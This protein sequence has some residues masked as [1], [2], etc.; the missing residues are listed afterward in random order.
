[1]AEPTAPGTG[2]A[3][4]A[5]APDGVPP[6][7]S[8]SSSS[9]SAYAARAAEEAARMRAERPPQTEAP[10]PDQ[11]PPQPEASKKPDDTVT[12]IIDAG[13]D[14][15]VVSRD[16]IR[17]E[18]EGVVR[19]KIGQPLQE[20]GAAVGAVWAA[21]SLLVVGLLFIAVAALVWL[22]QLIGVPLAFL[23][24]GLVYLIG[25][26]VFL[27]LKIRQMRANAEALAKSQELRGV[28]P[29]PDTTARKA[30]R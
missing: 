7:P 15:L 4:G 9:S 14:L 24:V 16:W 21:A 13:A 30:T 3:P 18:T 29:P 6:G 19:E 23:V 11:R 28:Q 22:C 26:A 2:P 17:Q 1:M 27:F 8:V 20:V 5:P 10:P 12:Q 25:S